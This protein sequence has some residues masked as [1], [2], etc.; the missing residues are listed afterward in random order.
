MCEIFDCLN[1]FLLKTADKK[2]TFAN[3]YTITDLET[4]KVIT[5]TS[6]IIYFQISHVVLIFLKPHDHSLDKVI[7]RRELKLFRNDLII[8]I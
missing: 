7:Y 3:R 4:G 8:E 5:F 2:N 1:S 6:I